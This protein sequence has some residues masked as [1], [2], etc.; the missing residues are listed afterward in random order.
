MN[1]YISPLTLRV[2][3]EKDVAPIWTHEGREVLRGL[4]G[5]LFFA[6]PLLYTVELWERARNVPKWDLLL[7]LILTYFANVGY[8]SFSN[9]K[10]GC[11][12][13]NVWWDSVVAMGIGVV[14]SIVTLYLTARFTFETPQSVLV[15][16]LALMTVPTSFGA[17][18]AIKQLGSREGNDN[19]CIADKMSGDLKKVTATI[20]G[21]L[22]FTFNIAPTI[23][24]KLML[25]E[26]SWLHAIA[27]VFF[28]LLIS[29]VI[30]YTAQFVQSENKSNHKVLGSKW[31]S[32]LVT[33]LIAL[34]TGGLLLW[35]FGYINLSVPFNMWLVWVIII[36]YA[37]TI[38]GAAGRLIL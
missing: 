7:I 26:V 18:V 21:A 1:K 16:L 34:T 12:R 36:G 33:Y 24:P 14:G 30:E 3:I 32:T 20:L 15:S 5:S 31:L 11:E 37:A 29:Y 2:R 35:M 28:S 6:L 27:I 25:A 17:S 38:G 10:S 8:V 19:D 9:F 22:L 13:T 23:E 4:A